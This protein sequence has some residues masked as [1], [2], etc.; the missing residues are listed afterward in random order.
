MEYQSFRLEQV[1]K[2]LIH[3]EKK[4]HELHLQL[5]DSFTRL[6]NACQRF[7]L[8]KK[9]KMTWQIE[10]LLLTNPHNK[11]LSQKGTLDACYSKLIH[12]LVSSII[13]KKHKVEK[14]SATLEALNPTNILK[15]GYS[16]TRTIPQKNIVYDSK[17]VDIHQQLE[18]VFSKGK[19]TCTVEEKLS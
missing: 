3:P 1:Q 12:F 10:R 7:H 4:L 16:I 14:L 8:K 17:S 11:I 5:D 15:R 9:D 2:R 19:I 6:I 18:I 13:N